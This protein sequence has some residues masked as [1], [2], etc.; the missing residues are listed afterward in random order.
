[1]DRKS[2]FHERFLFGKTPI[3]RQSGDL[4]VSRFSVRR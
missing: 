1:V 3:V 2:K 4:Y